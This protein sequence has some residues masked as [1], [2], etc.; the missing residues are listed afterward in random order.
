MIVYDKIFESEEE[1]RRFTEYCDGLFSEQILK[2]AEAIAS[3]H[4]VRFI[5]LSGPTCSGKT[6][7]ASLLSA[8][9]TQMGKNIRTVS[10]DDFYKDSDKS[11]EIL[12][13]VDYESIDAIDYPYFAAVAAALSAGEPVR[14][15]VYDFV[16]GTRAGYQDFCPNADTVIIFEG[17]QVVYPEIAALFTR[18]NCKR[19]L[20]SVG[21]E[22]LAYGRHFSDREIRFTRRIIR[23]FKFRG[24][25]PEGTFRMWKTVSENE[26]RNIY[27]YI[28]D[29]DIVLKS[30]VPYEINVM[31]PL[32]LEALAFVPSISA[33]ADAAREIAAKYAGIQ[34][35]SPDYVGEDSFFREFIGKI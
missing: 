29:M 14:L 24:T 1:K 25:P 32:I 10:I 27:P 9:L 13:T 16:T 17:I 4:R 15:P 35:I 21:D 30:F 28:G 11:G 22:V 5:L 3:D 18:E 34:S 6:A 31:A 20:I 12:D 19:I 33:F 26:D 2:C 8:A 23:D 7:A